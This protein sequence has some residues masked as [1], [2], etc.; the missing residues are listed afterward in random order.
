MMPFMS[1]YRLSNSMPFGLGCDVSTGTST[2][3]MVCTSS[4]MQSFT[5]LGYLGTQTGE[6]SGW[7]RQRHKEE[8]D[9]VV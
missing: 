5:T 8:L 2:S 7:R 9:W 4:S 3:P 1:R 6:G